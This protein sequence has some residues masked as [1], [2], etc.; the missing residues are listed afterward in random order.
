MHV[1]I[2]AGEPSGDLHAANLARA[3]AKLHAESGSATPLRLAGL[4]GP[5]SVAAGVTQLYPL[6]DLAIMWFGRAMLHLPKFFAVA[7]D[8]RRYFEQEKPD[9]VVVID[10]PGF[11]WALARRAKE[12]GVPVYYF[13]PPQLWAWAGWR[14]AKVKRYF[15]AVL[16]ALPFEEA[17][18][19]SRGVRTHYV[20]HP[21][22]DEIAGQ[23]LDA[24]F[25][26]AERVKPGRLVTILPGSRTQEVVGNGKLLLCAAKLVAEAVPG[27]RFAVAA[28]NAKQAEIIRALAAELGVPAEVHVGRTAELIE[29]CE[30]SLAVSG[31]VALELLSRLKPAVI[32][33]RITPFARLVSK[34]FITCKY[35]SL[36]NLLA[37]VEIYPEFLTTTGDP[38]PVAA[39]VIRWLSDGAARAETVAKLEAL[40][41]VVAVPGACERAAR[42]LVAELAARSGGTP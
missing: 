11:H 7:A 35:I 4:G 22:F 19:Q 41:G 1:F 16:T 34:Q 33:Y 25:L 42:F 30:C 13:V 14:S 5:K 10:Y 23:K 32:V 28:F 17:W 36:V 26:A 2:S 8:A 37:D 12:S 27:V 15:R 3:L 40:R 31:S 38:A 18:Y 39:P 9:A 29:A 20:G 6:T 21:Y 24:E